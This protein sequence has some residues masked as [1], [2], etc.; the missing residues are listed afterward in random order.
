M[1]RYRLR[2]IELIFKEEGKFDSAFA[3]QKNSKKVQ[4]NIS[5]KL[6][7]MDINTLVIYDEVNSSKFISVRNALTKF[8]V[9]SMIDLSV[10]DPFFIE[11][12]TKLICS[13]E[14]SIEAENRFVDVLTKPID[15][16]PNV[17]CYDSE[18][19]PIK[20]IAE[21]DGIEIEISTDTKLNITYRNVEFTWVLG[22]DTFAIECYYQSI[23]VSNVFGAGLKRTFAIPEIINNDLISRFKHTDEVIIA[24]F[25][26]N[27]T[28]L[29]ECINMIFC[30]SCKPISHVKRA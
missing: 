23:I 7:F 26:G 12:A 27:F 2:D 14:L 16:V 13:I 24:L 1:K 3:Q 8:Q 25:V 20:Y 21:V 10:D 30:P 17:I 29:R 6:Y 28:E 22:S 5:N 11:L 18:S 9:A 19:E 4:L 15:C